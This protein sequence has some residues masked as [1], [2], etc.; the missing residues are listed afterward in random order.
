MNTN[1]YHITYAP[2]AKS[3]SLYFWG[4]NMVCRGCIRQKEMYDC[5]LDKVKDGIFEEEGKPAGKPRRFLGFNQIQDILGDL[6]VNQV[7]FMG[8]EASLD[9]KLTEL[10]QFLHQEFHSHNILLTNGLR[11]IPMDHIDEVVM[12]IKAYQDSLSLDYTGASSEQV[13]KN[14]IR[15]HSWG[16][17][18]RAESV[19][20]PDYIDHREIGRIAKFIGSVDRTLP[21]RI[22]AYIP[23]G[24]NLWPQATSNEVEKGVREARKYLSNVSCLKGDQKLKYKVK[25]IY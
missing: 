2:E 10:A 5:H 18:L 12:S 21:Y 15:V 9:P 23:I 22:D 19:Y 17:K 13:L 14:F 24:D 16:K 7:I 3:V 11:L 20:I 8:M 4:C 6:D 25:R 1:I